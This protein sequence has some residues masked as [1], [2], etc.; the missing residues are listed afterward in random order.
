MDLEQLKRDIGEKELRL[1]QLRSM[2]THKLQAEDRRLISELEDEISK[3]K[4]QLDE[5]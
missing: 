1:S 3:L 2:D 4:E 5:A